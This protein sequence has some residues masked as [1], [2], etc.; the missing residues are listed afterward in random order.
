MKFFAC[1]ILVTIMISFSLFLPVN[2]DMTEKKIDDRMTKYHNME[3]NDSIM[4]NEKLAVTIHVQ[5]HKMI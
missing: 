4:I 2:A 3:I 5:N 1:A